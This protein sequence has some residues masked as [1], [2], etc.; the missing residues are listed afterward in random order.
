ML[1]QAPTQVSFSTPD[2]ITVIKIQ[3]DFHAVG[4]KAKVGMTRM[5]TRTIPTHRVYIVIDGEPG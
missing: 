2:A 3:P 4:Y 5:S 1:P